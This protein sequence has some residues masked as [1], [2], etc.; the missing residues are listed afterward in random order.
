[1]YSSRECGSGALFQAKETYL[2]LHFGEEEKPG[3]QFNTK[4]MQKNMFGQQFKILQL[5]KKIGV[6]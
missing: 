2:N 4:M 6:I 1:M 3:P 5:K